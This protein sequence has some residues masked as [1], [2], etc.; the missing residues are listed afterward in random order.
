M[1]QSRVIVFKEIRVNNETMFLWFKLTDDKRGIEP[2]VI[3][4]YRT[5]WELLKAD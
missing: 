3:L 1:Y 4:D 5:H 2:D